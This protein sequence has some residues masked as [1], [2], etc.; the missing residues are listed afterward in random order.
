MGALGGVALRA[1][2][3]AALVSCGGAEPESAPLDREAPCAELSWDRAARSPDLVLVV[4]DT[5]RRDRFGLYGGPARTPHFDRLG[6]EALA[7]TRAYSAAPWT[8]PSMASLF[9]GLHPSQHG[10]LSHPAL[11]RAADS[12]AA[13]EV[14]TDIL[15]EELE[16]LA[17]VLLAAGYETAAFVGNPW[18]RP[19]FGFSQGFEH[20]DDSF[21]ADDVAGERVVDAALR[22]LAEREGAR[23]YFL[24]VHTMDS[25]APYPALSEAEVRE[26]MEVPTTGPP[27][28]PRARESLRRAL[29]LEDGRPLSALGIP[30]TRELLTR[31]YDRGIEQFDTALGRLLEGL[32]NAGSAPALVVTSDHGEA[33]FERGW[34]GHGHA[35]FEADVA[36]PLV[37]RLPGVTASGPVTCPVAGVD[38]MSSLCAYVGATCPEHDFGVPFLGPTESPARWIVS[39]GVLGKP[40]HR[41]VRNR[42]WSLLRAPE[43]VPVPAPVPEPWALYPW[44]E[45]GGETSSV[46]ASHP[47]GVGSR[48]V[49][50]AIESAVPPF[51]APAA[52]ETAVDEATRARLEALGYLE[53]P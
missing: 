25:H 37:A 46:L 20:F 21:A 13:G 4:G 50:E 2:V 22:W 34:G 12:G 29:R 9:T 49:S 24:Y 27:L 1:A 39:E 31:A 15:A 41:A 10:V 6:A 5:M 19:D 35:L 51:E 53:A 36:V 42:A 48:E 32:E 7:F 28:G 16:T 44:N 43:G 33:L 47:G 8:K 38:L 3:L 17:E 40:E 11:R 23:P 14:V 30:P 18:L 26:S 45:H 52:V